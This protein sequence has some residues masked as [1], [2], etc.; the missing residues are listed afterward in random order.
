MTV[1]IIIIIIIVTVIIVIFIV[2]KQRPGP[3]PIL[4]VYRQGLEPQAPMTDQAKLRA[5]PSSCEHRH[6]WLLQGPDTRADAPS[7]G[8]ASASAGVQNIMPATI[9]VRYVQ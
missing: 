2:V 4:H 6:G 5:V 1:F 9:G 3:L 7:Q 8:R